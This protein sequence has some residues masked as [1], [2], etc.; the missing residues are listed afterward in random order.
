MSQA[1]EPAAA[2]L[3]KLVPLLSSD[4]PSE[5]VATVAAI[6]RTLASAGIDFN[7]LACALPAA[8]IECVAEQD[9]PTVADMIVWLGRRLDLLSERE[10]DF[11]WNL[12]RLRRTP[13]EKQVDWLRALYDRERG[14]G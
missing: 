10:R 6:G 8:L 4:K 11:V 5:I 2:K 9:E 7:D 3:A 12:S 14:N 13:T 1:I